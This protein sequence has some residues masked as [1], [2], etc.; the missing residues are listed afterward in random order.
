MTLMET[1][2]LKA[3]KESIAKWE[4]NAELKGADVRFSKHLGID[5]CPL[6]LLFY[7]Y[8]Q[9]RICGN[10]PVAEQGGTTG[11]ENTPYGQCIRITD[12]CDVH[13]RKL[14][15]PAKKAA[16]TRKWRAAC[17]KEVEF[18]KSLLPAA[19]TVT[20]KDKL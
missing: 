10:C 8:T 13:L 4:K 1:Y 9:N 20:D 12:N 7:S 6:C 17:R 3:L 5:N 2:T 15:S 19:L 16:L 11:C 14:D 18:L